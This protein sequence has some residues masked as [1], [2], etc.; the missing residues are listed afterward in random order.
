MQRKADQLRAEIASIS[1]LLKT[2]RPDRAFKRATK[3]AKKW[4][5]VAALPRLAGIS[6]VQQQ[7]PKL[8]QTHFEQAWRLDPGN[9]ELTQN[10][11]LSLVQGGDPA[12]ALAFLD[13]IAA[14]GPFSPALQFIRA[15]ALL[16][17]QQ[18]EQA[19]ADVEQV[20]SREPA[21]PN[22]QVLKADILD[23]MHRWEDAVN[24]LTAL[25]K[26]QPKFLPGLLRLTRSQLGLGQLG[27]VLKN[28]RAALVLAPGHPEALEIMAGLPNLTF[29]DIATLHAQISGSLERGPAANPE[30]EVK[31]RFA[32]ANLARRQK[33]TKQEM[34]HLA[35]A[36]KL[37]RSRFEAWEERSAKD[38]V[39]RLAAP[40]P[41]ANS[42]EA[43]GRPR[44]IFVVGLPRSGTTLVERILARHSTVQGLGEL[45]SVHQWARQA[46]A[47]PAE[48]RAANKLADYYVAKLPKLAGDTAAFVDKAPGNYA[49]LGE[50]AQ[51]FPDAV[52][53]NVL[54]D[55][56][57]VA[58][59]MWR[60]NFGAGGLYYTHDLRWMA[61]EANRYQRYMRHWHEVLPGRIHDIRYEALV[62]NLQ[63]TTEELA[64][65]CG[66]AFEDTMLTPD[67]SANAIRTASNLQARQPVNTASIGGW[68]AV[69]DQ[70]EPFV[71]GLDAELWPELV[72]TN[73]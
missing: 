7:K 70:L 59:S 48:W 52:I 60:A 3:A 12:D 13:K 43:A 31:L 41:A 11:A 56:R 10:Y 58:L 32:A 18:P 23:S 72:G 27:D 6:A 28:V 64:R 4:P 38:C 44:L 55:P 36:H 17:E 34:Q 14:R 22:A 37:Q 40:L 2:G 51:A 49:F 15:L 9:A 61:A 62:G 16:Q 33:N 71:K 63:E 47:Q 68:Q 24:V 8:A 29:D 39:R 30:D 73:S 69:A 21:N 42:G 45:A 26:K 65:I 57:D 46:E 25:V 20:L 54:R 5:K 50:I 67:Q 66:L 35:E 53:L 1:E 19:L